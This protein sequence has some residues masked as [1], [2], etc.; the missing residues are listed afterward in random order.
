LERTE[1][2]FA[3]FNS[4]LS[5]RNIARIASQHLPVL[6]NLQPLRVSGDLQVWRDQRDGNGF[7][8]GAAL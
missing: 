1:D 2:C 8:A 7:L 4:G 6:P 3:G 5:S